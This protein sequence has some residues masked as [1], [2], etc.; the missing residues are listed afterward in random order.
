M[1][2]EL[3]RYHGIV[4]RQILM[5]HPKRFTVGV[6]DISGRKDAF[7]LNGAAFQIKN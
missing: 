4:L 2:P 5:A 7:Y 3:D 1:I 6:A